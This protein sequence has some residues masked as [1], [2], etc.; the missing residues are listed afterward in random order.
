M[1]NETLR[2]MFSC[3][4]AISLIMM[5]IM[6][7]RMDDASPWQRL[8]RNFHQVH[9]HEEEHHP[10]VRE[11]PDRLYHPTNIPFIRP[12]PRKSKPKEVDSTIKERTIAIGLGITT[13]GQL[14]LNPEAAPTELP[15]FRRLMLSF[16]Q[17]ASYGFEYHFYIA[18]DHSDPFFKHNISHITF[19]RYS[20]EFISRNCPDNINVTIHLVECL[21]SGRPAWAQNDA[22]MAAYMDNS[23]YYYRVNDDTVMETTGWTERMIQQLLRFNPPNIGVA[24]PW[25]RDGNTAILTHDF[26]HRTH[27]EIFGFYYPRVFTDWFA[28]DWITGVYCPDMCKKV[29]GVRVKHTME[30]GSRYV[31][32][33][34]KAN[35]V[36]MEVE[37][38]KNMINRYSLERDDNYKGTLWDRNATSVIA[39]TLY[40]NDP[41]EM[42]GVM[43]YAQLI[44][45]LMKGWRLRVYIYLSKDKET[46]SRLAKL[47]IRKLDKMGVE[48][49]NVDNEMASQLSP[50]M[51]RLLVADDTSLKH[52]IIRNPDT[53]P[54]PRE[55]ASL[56]DW[57]TSNNPL[58][59]IR[60]HPDHS[61][62]PLVPAL[63][64]GMPARLRK[65]LGQS[66]RT[67]MRGYTTD[68]SFLQEV[69]WPKL[70][71]HCL[72]H[73][74]V[75][76]QSWPGSRPYPTL[77][78]E[79][80]FVGQHY[81]ANDEP[82]S[83]DFR[84]WNDTYN[85]PDCVFMK[86]TG[87][88]EQAL[89]TV[90]KVRPVFWSQDYHVTPMMDIKSLLKPIGVKIIDKS[91][92]Y[93][94]GKVGT[95][96]KG[97]RIIT[98]ENG[99]RLTPEIIQ[100]FYQ[101]YKDN[102]D[103]KT[104]NAFICTLPVAMCEAFLP[105][106]KSII[107]IATIRYEQGR[108][109]PHKWRQLN[110]NLLT[111][112]KNP[113]SIIA[114]NNAY[115]QKYI[116]YFTGIKPLLVPNS[117]AYLQ[118]SY[119]PSRKQFLVT[120]I[121]NTEL[122]DKF[123]LQFDEAVIRQKVDINL[124]PLRQL[125]PQYVF[126]DL[127]AHPGIVYIPYQ[128][129]MVS[130]T[131]QYRM[132]IPL[133]FPSIDLLTVWH[134]E[135][136]VV[137]QRTWAGYLMRRSSAS[138]LPGVIQ[139]PDPNNDVDQ[140]AIKFWLK[141]ADFYQWPHITYYDSVEDLVTKLATTDLKAVSDRMKEHNAEVRQEIKNV[142]SK[143]LLK[144]VG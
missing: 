5:V 118:D 122:S 97:L 60:D 6:Y 48:V 106:N 72:C 11:P 76:C 58:H 35:R 19:S 47:M 117:C 9:D 8:P 45:I 33:F 109:E 2:V 99:M 83:I 18:H 90:I 102:L 128:V 140:D 78:S 68:E 116:E 111:I 29:A 15:F 61:K 49:V 62:S 85:S 16:C 14:D 87:F 66:W 77:R 144:T 133:F 110:Q 56:K 108:P 124:F 53:R 120:P 42:F 1:K 44:P 104:V 88:D 81:D 20:H 32:H 64:G 26:V 136:Q 70:K 10:L 69:I 119:K 67:L 142:W 114:A 28:D 65:I 123:Y 54:S 43:R 80:E 71:H 21:H 46:Y 55:A 134:A 91:L 57:L 34:E 38:G 37:I 141:Y 139:A 51:W 23:A 31:V 22:M 79:N 4:A 89:R 103:M 39:M 13:R 112:S 130:L 36:G 41:N 12:T 86:N 98:R 129:S 143:M 63:I 74:S 107:I 3:I 137:R 100:Q 138:S 131:E 132:N 27:I 93:Y 92:S 125:Y 24:G 75:S 73:D 127:A 94:C 101:V 126:G 52:F 115:D 25:F 135:Y 113:R 30:M 96:A 95:C 50:N 82:T 40:G 7:V 59:C 84:S 121:H 105:F 17:T